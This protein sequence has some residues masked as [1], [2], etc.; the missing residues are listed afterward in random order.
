M[1]MFQIISA[2]DKGQQ[3]ELCSKDKAMEL[4]T[5][6]VTGNGSRKWCKDTKKSNNMKKNYT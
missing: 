4:Q 2:W 3:R 1:L 6:L 5:L